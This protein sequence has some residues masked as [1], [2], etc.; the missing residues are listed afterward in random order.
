MH[1]NLL[2]VIKGVNILNL[3]ILW[4]EQNPEKLGDTSAELKDVLKPRQPIAKYTFDACLEPAFINELENA[5]V[6][7]WLVVGIESHICV[8]QTV[9]GLINRGYGVEII[10]ECIA[11]RKEHNKQIA[12]QKIQ[13]LGGKITSVEMCLYELVKDCRVPEFKQILNL[14]R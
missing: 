4:L 14:I 11:S 3:P 13:A 2:S 6:S 7:N 8:Y 12:L 1:Q 10:Q 5:N 9:K